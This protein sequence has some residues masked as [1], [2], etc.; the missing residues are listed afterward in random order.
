MTT[1]D[2]ILVH[3]SYRI[4]GRIGKMKR[5]KPLSGN[6]FASNLIHAEIFTPKTMEEIERLRRE[7]SSLQ[8]Q[9]DFELREV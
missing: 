9:G 6:T 1:T 5:M 2:N 8:S 7:V 4:Y 3:T